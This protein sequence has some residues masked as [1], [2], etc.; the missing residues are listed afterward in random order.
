SL[1][2]SVSILGRRTRTAESYERLGRGVDG[3]RAR[4]ETRLR[5]W[6]ELPCGLDAER[7]ADRLPGKG[8]KT[9]APEKAISARWVRCVAHRPLRSRKFWPALE[10][11]MIGAEAADASVVADEN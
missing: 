8:A 2:S 1:T 5:R 4:D 7:R 6:S 11:A 3:E 10:G 9:R